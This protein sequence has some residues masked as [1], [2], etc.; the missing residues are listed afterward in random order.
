M[1]AERDVDL[2]V[3]EATAGRS[4]PVRLP[5]QVAADRIVDRLVEVWRLPGVGPDGQAL[6]YRFQLE[7]GLAIDDGETLSDAGVKENEVLRLVAHE[8][9]AEPTAPALAPVPSTYEDPVD[10]VATGGYAAPDR[11]SQA[12]GGYRRTTTVVAAV[13]VLL[14]AGVAAVLATG[15]LS[16]GSHSSGI[17]KPTQAAVTT[18]P[19]QATTTASLPTEAEQSSDRS[20]IVPLLDYYQS[21]YSEHDES[22]LAGLFTPEVS[23]HGLAAG[24]CV[25][26]HGLTAVMADYRNQ[27][28]A[29]SGSY[30]LVGLSEGQIQFDNTT[31]ARLN[32]HYTLTP[33]NSGYVNFTFEELGEGWKISEVNAA[34]E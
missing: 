26:S 3:I 29:G 30:E 5:D 12:R 20:A 33:G 10:R 1:H 24:G 18:S 19:P 6:S 11:S 14:G 9:G 32:S 4:E 27:F 25:V 16:R 23:R 13:A 34:C 7:S 17:S 15:A 28:E 22:A 8:I 31:R 21:D 2:T